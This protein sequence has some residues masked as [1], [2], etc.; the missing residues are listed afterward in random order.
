MK[1]IKINKI[2]LEDL[3]IHK[4]HEMTFIEIKGVGL[5]LRCLDC[6]SNVFNLE[7]IKNGN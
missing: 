5:I 3:M 7:E 6:H 4:N 2:E 1:E